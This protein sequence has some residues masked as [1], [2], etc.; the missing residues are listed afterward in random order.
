MEQNERLSNL[1]SNELAY[2]WSAYEYETMAKCGLTSF[3][4]HINDERTEE[5]LKEVVTISEA[6]IEKIKQFF[7]MEKCPVPLGFTDDDINFNAPRLF[8]DTLYLE[9]MLQ[10]IQMELANYAL[11]FIGAIKPDLQQFYENATKE[12]MTVKTKVKQL[13]MDKGIYIPAPRI[14]TPKQVTFVTKDRFLAGWFGEKRPLLGMEIAHLVFNA[15]RNGV[16]QAV[17]TGFSQVAQS[18]EVRKFFER[19]R[20]IAVKSVDVFSK[21]LNEYYL[22]TSTKIW[23]SEVT[24]SKEPPFSDKLMLQMITSLIASG[25]SS[26]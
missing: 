1:T 12:S 25:M 14:P 16:G 24:D 23:T 7:N 19:G 3:L 17:I 2:L 26:Y 20:D 4:Q 21:L 5:I 13:A 11:A 8:S 6:R 9:F 10:L 18:K 15:K 22:P